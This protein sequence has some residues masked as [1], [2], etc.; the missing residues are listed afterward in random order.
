[1]PLAFLTLPDLVND[2]LPGFTPVGVSTSGRYVMCQATTFYKN[3]WIL[4][5][6]DDSFVAYSDAEQ[7]NVMNGC[8]IDDDDGTV[9]FTP[10][11]DPSSIYAWNDLT[12]EPGTTPIYEVPSSSSTMAR[13]LRLF[14]MPDA[15]KKLVW[16]LNDNQDVPDNLIYI[17]DIGTDTGTPVTW[18][19][20]APHGVVQD[21]YGDVWV[22]GRS[23]AA[24]VVFKRVLDG[25]AGTAADDLSTADIPHDHPF[26]AQLQALHT[27][28]GW[29]VC[30][31]SGQDL[32]L[33]DDSDFSIIA[34]RSY[35]ATGSSLADWD[36]GSG[37]PIFL[38]VEPGLGSFWFPGPNSFDD[39]GAGPISDLH[40]INAADLT[41]LETHDVSD[42]EVGDTPAANTPPILFSSYDRIALISHSYGGEV[43]NYLPVIRYFEEGGDETGEA[44]LTDDDVRLRVWGYVLDGHAYAVFRVGPSASLILDLSTGQW[45]RWASPAQ[46]KWRA[47]VGQNWIGMGSTTMARG[48]GSDVVCGDDSTGILWILDPTAGADDDPT[49]GEPV[50]FIREVTAGIP[51]SGREVAPCN[52]VTMGLTLGDPTQTG[53]AIELETSDDNGNTWV[54]HGTVTVTAGSYSQVVEWRSLGLMRAPGRIFKFTDNGATVRIA[55]ADMR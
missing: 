41:T 44:G 38:M 18:P 47:H 39:Y 6:S 24:T 10:S 4:D 1:M 34:H 31:N 15:S 46:D 16:L 49:T 17:Y 9:Y 3:I 12:A 20:G 48:F 33:L 23:D 35:A 51:L 28:A 11:S 40:K 54:S 22:Y 13:S 50:Q 27:S 26:G 52:A 42:W 7:Y 36:W 55:W 8:A 29:F 30:A 5:R 25:G 19:Y 37:I 53:A 2:D 45:S 43:S 21:S 14:L 32:Y